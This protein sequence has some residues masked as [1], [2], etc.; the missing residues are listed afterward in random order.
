MTVTTR[1]VW[2]ADESY[3]DVTFRAAKDA[4]LATA[5]AAG[6]LGTITDISALVCN[7]TWV[8]DAAAN[9]WISY[10]TTSATAAGYG[11]TV[12]KL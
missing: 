8:D 3:Q 11:L 9:E 10:I 2:T 6:K 4:W 1:Q 12:T 5:A 7:R